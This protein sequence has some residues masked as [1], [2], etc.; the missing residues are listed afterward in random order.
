MVI[1]KLLQKWIYIL[2]IFT[3]HSDYCLLEQRSLHLSNNV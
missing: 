3:T 1:I 2:L